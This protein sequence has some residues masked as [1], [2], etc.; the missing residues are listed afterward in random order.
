MQSRRFGGAVDAEVAAAEAAISNA[1]VPELEE[2]AIPP[3]EP[4]RDAAEIGAGD[5]GEPVTVEA[6]HEA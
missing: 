4:F 1:K 6:Q 3:V 5:S 2:A